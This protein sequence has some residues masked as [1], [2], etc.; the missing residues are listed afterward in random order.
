MTEFS[1]YLIERSGYERSGFPERYDEHRPR[2]PRAL[3]DLLCR[4]AGVERPSLVVD[5]GS[6]TGLSTR[7]WAGRAESVVGV[8][9]NPAMLRRAE[10]GTDADNVR[11]V[12]AYADSTGLADDS[13]DIVCCSQAFHWMDPGPVL[14][15][16]ARVLRPGGVFAAYDYELPPVVSWEVDAAFAEYHAARRRARRRRD[17]QVGGDRWPKEGH[18]NSIGESGHFHFAREILLHSVEERG[19]ADRVVGLARSIGPSVEDD[20]EVALA[21]ERLAEVAGRAL[22]DSVVPWHLGYRVR[23]GVK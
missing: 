13:V 6:G 3:L 12:G 5:L 18:L 1:Q 8:E 4:L 23:A 9:P 2:P 11:Y 22:G 14:G 16:A 15:E 21:L 19:G 17:L 20:D 7:A 10:E